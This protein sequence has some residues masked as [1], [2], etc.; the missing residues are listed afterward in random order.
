M[1]FDRNTTPEASLTTES[2]GQMMLFVTFIVL[3]SIRSL[4]AEIT[5]AF[6]SVLHLFLSLLPSAK[7]NP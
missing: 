6:L 2:N 4:V 5:E 1:L 7:T 3:I